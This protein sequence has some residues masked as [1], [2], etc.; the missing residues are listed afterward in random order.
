MSEHEIVGLK[1]VGY[2][3]AIQRAS[4][5]ERAECRLCRRRKVHRPRAECK[6][7]APGDIFPAAPPTRRTSG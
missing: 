7:G 6:F 2:M 3:D 5:V 4:K 1:R